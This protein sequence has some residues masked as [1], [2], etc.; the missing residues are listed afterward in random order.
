MEGTG[1][2]WVSQGEKA[3]AAPPSNRPSQCAKAQHPLPPPTGRRLYTHV[4]VSPTRRQPR[5]SGHQPSLFL[6]PPLSPR[7]PHPWKTTPSP[8]RKRSNG[9]SMAGAWRAVV[10]PLA[11]HVEDRDGG[12]LGA[13]GQGLASPARRHRHPQRAGDAELAGGRLP[14]LSCTLI[15]SPKKIVTTTELPLISKPPK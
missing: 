6:N 14:A 15:K 11:G 3:T 4:V 5:P 1:L 2:K 8:C 7:S 10:R 13:E 9:N 12:R